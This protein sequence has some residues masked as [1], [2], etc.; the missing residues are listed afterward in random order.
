METACTHINVLS[1]NYQHDSKPFE[2]LPGILAYTTYQS[3]WF[4]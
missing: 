1:F 4:G 3:Y 2:M